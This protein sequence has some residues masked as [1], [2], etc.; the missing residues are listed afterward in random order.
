MA[1]TTIV[2]SMSSSAQ[3]LQAKRKPPTEARDLTERHEKEGLFAVTVLGW[4]DIEDLLR[5]H[6]AVLDW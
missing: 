2:L 1:G 5:Q 4:E 3:R 6:S